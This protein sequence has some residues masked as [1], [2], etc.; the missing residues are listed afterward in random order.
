MT[1]ASL[2]WSEAQSECR[3]ALLAAFTSEATV[4]CAALRAAAYIL[5]S[6]GS[7]FD[8]ELL[9]SVGRSLSHQ[10]VE[11]RRVAAVV[12]GHILR[13]APCQLENSLLKVVVP[14]LVN[15]AKESNSAVRSASELALVYAFHFQDGQDGFDNYLLSVEGAAKTILSELQ[16]ALR[17]VVRNADLTF[18]PVSNILAVS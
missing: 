5:I 2:V 10:S 13:S 8:R 15:G 9:S 11:V 14:H 4:A 3:N 7:N 17:R 12:L 18:E 1:D 6:E 16:P